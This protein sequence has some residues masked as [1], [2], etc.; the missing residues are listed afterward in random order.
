MAEALQ[1][2]VIRRRIAAAKAQMAEGSPGADRGWR[3]ALARAAR[4]TLALPLEVSS[5]ALHRRSLAEVLELPPNHALIAV[6]QG[7]ADGMGLMILSPPVL[8]A[9]I[10]AQTLGK[11]AATLLTSRK[12][13]RTDAAM[14]APTLDAALEGLEQVLAQEADLHW[15]GGFR[16]A[17]FLDDPRPLGL[18][19]ED[20]DYRVL[21][22]ELSLGLG[23]RQGAVILALPAD[24]KGAMP[25][26]AVS[27]PDLAAQSGQAFAQALAAQVEE[28]GCVLDAVVSRVSLPL[29]RVLALKVGEIIPLSRASIDRIH[30]EG[31]DGRRLA[32]GRLGQNRGMRAIRLTSGDVQVRKAS[33]VETTAGAEPLRQTG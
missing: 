19:L 23:A 31:L 28:T 6:L 2:G 27:V 10:E 1:D 22:A 18:L 5:L 25:A 9:M 17:S 15:A 3:L 4:D 8:A 30:F 33:A 26:A 32:E 24:G 21:T 20:I 13:T 7:P 12:P 14:V 11:V 16:Y 29:A